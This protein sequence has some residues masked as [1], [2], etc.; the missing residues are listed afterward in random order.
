MV[1][2]VREKI[3][4]WFGHVQSRDKDDTTRNILQITVDEKPNRGRPKLRWR[5][6]ETEDITRN[7]MATEMAEDIT[8]RPIMIQS[9]TLRS[10]EAETWNEEEPIWIKDR[11]TFCYLI[12]TP[13]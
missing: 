4:R 12:L 8:H 7:V 6:L 11:S 10:L 5:D 9:G 2:F 3:L 13:K 1:Y